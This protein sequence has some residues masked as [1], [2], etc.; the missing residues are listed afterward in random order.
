MADEPKAT[1]EELQAQIAEITKQL[2]EKDGQIASLTTA[3][4]KAM[5]AQSKASSEAA[6]AKK[7]LQAYMTDEE[8]AKEEQDAMF[9][10]LQEKVAKYEKENLV[11]TYQDSYLS[12]QYSPEYA[13]QAA[14]AMVAND[15]ETVMKVQQAHNA[16]LLQKLQEE[17][18]QNTPKPPAGTPPK[19]NPDDMSDE[20]Y[21]AALKAGQI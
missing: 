7:K 6:D 19:G 18:L 16:E 13:R 14:E 20:E 4:Q 3:N 12:M 17:A 21:Y 2:E 15:M 1:I 9:K 8:R 11:R 5:A 10:E